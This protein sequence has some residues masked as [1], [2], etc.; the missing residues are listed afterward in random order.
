MHK[1]APYGAISR[2]LALLLLF[3]VLVSGQAAARTLKVATLAPEGSAWMNLLREGAAQVAERTDGRVRF[4]FYPGGVMGNDATVLRKMRIGQ[5]QGGAFT[6]GALSQLYPDIQIYSLPLLFRSYEEVDRVRSDL[7]TPIQQGLEDK[8]LVPLGLAE[9]GFIYLFSREP[10]ASVEDVR[11]RKVWI[12]EGD[13]VS[14]AIVESADVASVPLSLG[15]VYT[16]L[17]T[18]LVDT[19]AAS[20]TAAIAF[21][22]HTRVRAMTD[23]PLIYVVGTVALDRKVFRRLSDDDQRVVRQSMGEALRKLDRSNRAEDAQA[24]MALRESGV[25]FVRPSKAALQSWRDIAARATERLRDSGAFRPETLRII[26][27]T[28][29]D[30]RNGR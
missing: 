29:A 15:D 19:V 9:G 21:Q 2:L 7:D 23:F 25:E 24:R 14:E 20:P 11:R 13:Q 27:A 4:K 30:F 26:E 10:V 3:S 5:L 6:V 17:Q 18:D 16:A 8:G 1:H 22:W 28:L 12:P